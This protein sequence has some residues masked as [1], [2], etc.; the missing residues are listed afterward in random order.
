MSVDFLT[1]TIPM[2]PPI[3]RIRLNA[4]EI[5][6]ALIDG[7]DRSRVCE[8]LSICRVRPLSMKG[9][10]KAPRGV[11]EVSV[12]RLED[13]LLLDKDD[14]D[15][16]RTQMGDEAVELLDY[17]RARVAFEREWAD[18]YPEKYSTIK[19][20][21]AGLFVGSGGTSEEY[22]RAFRKL[23]AEH[24]NT[25]VSLKELAKIYWTAI[26]SVMSAED[27]HELAMSRR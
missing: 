15:F 18:A 12:D 17:A 25:D 26:E 4:K 2:G 3:G 13:F 6:I 23:F 9:M 5:E 21:G 1:R 11:K 10:P 8:V 14:A 22:W 16:W 20:Y 24:D 19:V 7:R 27:F